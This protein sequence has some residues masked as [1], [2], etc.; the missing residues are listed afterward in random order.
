MFWFLTMLFLKNCVFSSLLAQ[1]ETI[2]LGDERNF[3][4]ES[5]GP[6][7]YNRPCSRNHAEHK[8]CVP[9][10]V[11]SLIPSAINL[12]SLLGS[13]WIFSTFKGAKCVFWHFLF[14][15][16]ARCFDHIWYYS[17]IQPDQYSDTFYLQKEPD[18]LTIL[19]E[20]GRKEVVVRF[21]YF[22]W[23]VFAPTGTFFYFL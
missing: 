10:V 15:N 11:Q 17:T 12:P 8:Q 1:L 13:G 18:A 7:L 14:S 20:C 2:C 16:G 5:Y 3:A 4:L 21:L 22:L 19:R 6:G 23:S 9:N